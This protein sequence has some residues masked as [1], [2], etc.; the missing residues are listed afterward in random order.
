MSMRVDMREFQAALRDYIRVSKRTLSDILNRKLFSILLKAYTYTPKATREQIEAD[1]NVVAYRVSRSR[2]TGK[3]KRR[4]AIFGTATLVY[5]IINA[6]RGRA[7]KKGFYGAQ[8]AKAARK[9]IGRRLSGIGALRMGWVGA[10]KKMENIVKQTAAIVQG[11]RV[12]QRGTAMPAR[13]GWSPKALA[14]YNLNV[15]KGPKGART[16]QI[17][18]R[19]ELALSRAFAYET[20]S[21]REYIARK[22]Q[23]VTNRF[24]ARKT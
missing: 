5:R 10:I 12:R 18:K 14:S 2:K 9:L 8:M 19:V 15:R 17:D 16:P 1:L 13:E 24:N 6:A 20:Q 3:M 11:P 21:M 7:K 22:M 4:N 23:P